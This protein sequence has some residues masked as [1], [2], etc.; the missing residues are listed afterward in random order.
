VSGGNGAM[1]GIL[2]ESIKEGDRWCQKA[3]DLRGLSTYAQKGI[4]H[5]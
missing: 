1:L 4:L 2:V 3:L 5:N